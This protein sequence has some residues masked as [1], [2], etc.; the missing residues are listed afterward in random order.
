[1]SV[2]YWFGSPRYVNF[3]GVLMDI[4]RVASNAESKINCYD[5][6]KGA[7]PSDYFFG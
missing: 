3:D 5:A 4:D 1:M 7:Q 2:D 6:W